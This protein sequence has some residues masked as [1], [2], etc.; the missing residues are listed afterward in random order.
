MIHFPALAN[1]TGPWLYIASE[2]AS[3]WV[4]VGCVFMPLALVVL[5][6]VLTS[7]PVIAG[8]GHIPQSS[9][10]GLCWVSDHPPHKFSNFTE[11]YFFS[12]EIS[13]CLEHS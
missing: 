8:S 6:L 9:A 4:Q 10:A 12:M 3:L 5:V 7:C 11:L 2:L 1:L 13:S